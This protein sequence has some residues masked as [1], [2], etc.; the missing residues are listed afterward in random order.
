MKTQPIYESGLS[1]VQ[2]HMTEHDCGLITANRFARDCGGGIPYTKIENRRRNAA[3]AARLRNAQYG[4]TTVDG[5]YS[6]QL[7][8]GTTQDVK[9]DTFFV[10]D[11]HDTGKLKADL[12]RWGFE[13]EQDA[14][15]FIGR[16]GMNATAIQTN[17]CNA[18]VPR[19]SETI[20]GDFTRFGIAGT[21]HTRVNNRPFTFTIR[22]G[23]NETSGWFGKYI[24][25]AGG[26][27]EW[28]RPKAADQTLAE[29][30]AT[31]HIELK[32]IGLYETKK[33]ADYKTTPLTAKMWILPDGKTV[34]LNAWHYQWL[35]DNPAVVAKYGLDLSNLPKEETPI[36]I[37]AIKTGFFRVNFEYKN[38]Q[39]T[40]EGV[41]RNYTRKIKDAI[42][43]LLM[44]NVK[45]IDRFKL[46]LTDENVT[47]VVSNKSVDLFTY[48]S[49]EEKMDALDDVIR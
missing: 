37:A 49:E 38:G 12:V 30:R 40:I 42:F 4:L 29:Y 41:R 24:D 43:V 20:V 48:G 47:S 16:G 25:F 21:F 17:N 10:V 28:F 39:L 18:E 7:P 6:E 36:R 15:I 32:R 22:D 9:E 35:L 5:T 3:L 45:S 46:T 11:L 2:K 8:N 27:Q 34:A 33:L 1:R 14:I 13:F 31:K 44:D 26:T 23:L 19:G